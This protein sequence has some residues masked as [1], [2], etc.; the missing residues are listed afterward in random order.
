MVHIPPSGS[1]LRV[2]KNGQNIIQ[3]RACVNDAE[4]H[5]VRI[6]YINILLVLL[7]LHVLLHLLS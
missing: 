4:L 6:R 5:G 2:P 3:T 7:L 1:H